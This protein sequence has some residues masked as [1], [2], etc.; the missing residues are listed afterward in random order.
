MRGAKKP[1][2]FVSDDTLLLR[3]GQVV[4]FAYV[5]S[6]IPTV[7][8]ENNRTVFYHKLCI[9]FFRI[10]PAQFEYKFNIAPFSFETAGYTP[11]DL[12]CIL[13]LRRKNI[14]A[15]SLFIN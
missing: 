6:D 7:L 12:F 10:K 9:I 2:H 15:S 1:I 4:A 5:V 3:L 11:D 8:I 14:V 13:C